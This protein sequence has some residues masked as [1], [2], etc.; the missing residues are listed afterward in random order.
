ME[1]STSAVT[2]DEIRDELRPSKPL[3]RFVD[4]LT[5]T[6]LVLGGV[7]F[8]TV[9][10]GLYSLA[11]R[12]RIAA[13]VADGR[14][15]STELT[16]AELIDVTH[17]LLTW[18]GVGMAVIGL[19]LALGGVA[20]LAYRSRVRRTSMEAAT[21]DV[22]VLAVVGAVVTVMTSFV[23]L[24]PVLGGLVSGYLRGGDAQGGARVG[25]YAGLVAS[26]PFALLT[27]FVLGGLAVATAELGLGGLGVFVG[28]AVVVSL[29][30]SVASLVG[31]SALGGYI[32][33]S[34]D[35]QTRDPVS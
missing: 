22:V 2:S 9:G 19:L 15:T 3:S 14:L 35:E 17:S 29:L 34:L 13:W 33:V 1:S 7:L 16:D 30:V 11:D 23:P 8:T 10:A 5:T 21:P 4:W 12:S 28:L 20:F 31:L 24:S 18:G 25:A 32:G 26:I 27:L 6:F